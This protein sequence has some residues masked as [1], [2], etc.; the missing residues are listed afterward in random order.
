MSRLAAD[1]HLLL[2]LHALDHILALQTRCRMGDIAPPALVLV[3]VPDCGG[4]YVNRPPA[5]VTDPMGCI[6][7]AVLS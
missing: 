2:L 1:A 6:S 4:S 5:D 3:S 7:R